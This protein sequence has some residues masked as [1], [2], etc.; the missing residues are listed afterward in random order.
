MIIEDRPTFVRTPSDVV[1]LPGSVAALVHASRAGF[2]VV[3]ISNQSCIGRGVTALDDAIHI[4]RELVG[5]LCAGGA[6]ILGSFLCPHAPE[7]GCECRK[8]SP[9][10][11]LAAIEMHGCGP[12]DVAF[13]GDSHGD[14]EAATRADVLP[15]LV[16]TGRGKHQEALVRADGRLRQVTVTSD[17]LSGVRHACVQLPRLPVPP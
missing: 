13:I 16:A 7:L 8:P 14:M 12:E 17:L 11:L 3:I 4:H 15:I 2:P 9:R 10:M 6:Q 1:L 5:T